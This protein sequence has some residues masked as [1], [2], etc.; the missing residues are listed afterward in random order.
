MSQYSSSG[1]EVDASENYMN[2]AGE[3]PTR[4]VQNEAANSE[5]ATIAAMKY[6]RTTETSDVEL[7]R[8]YW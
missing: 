4:V 3:S 2:G 7:R 8:H 6:A 5:S 1:S